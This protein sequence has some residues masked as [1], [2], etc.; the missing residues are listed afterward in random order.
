[1]DEL[2]LRSSG[3]GETGGERSEFLTL[4]PSARPPDA[5]LLRALVVPLVLLACA[6]LLAGC[7]GGSSSDHTATGSPSSSAGTGSG[8]A[9]PDAAGTASSYPV[10]ASASPSQEPVIGSRSNSDWTFT[11]NRVQPAGPGQLIVEGTLVSNGPPYLEYLEEPGF[12]LHKD[13][14]GKTEESHEFSA[15]SLSV[16]GD[17]TVYLPLRDADGQCACTRGVATVEVGKPFAVY[18]LLTAPHPVSEVTVLVKGFAP[19]TKVPVT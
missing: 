2:R 3:M 15:V 5:V 16:A 9:V 14:D 11:L 8:A 6:G 13:A 1:M 12:L 10:A 4:R 19:F 18:V 7:I 17:Q